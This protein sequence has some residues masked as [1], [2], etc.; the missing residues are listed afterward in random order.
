MQQKNLT[1][2]D[3]RLAMTGISQTSGNP[4]ISQQDPEY[5][6]QTPGVSV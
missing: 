5:K 3:C 2:S 6:F 4:N 1:V